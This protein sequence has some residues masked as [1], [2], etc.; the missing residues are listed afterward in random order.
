M[1]GFE[2]LVAG[3]A[4]FFGFHVLVGIYETRTF[5]VNM[6]GINMYR[7]LHSVGAVAGLSLIVLGFMDRP[8]VPVYAVTSWGPTLTILVLPIAVIFLAG[9]KG[10]PDMLRVT[11]H[12]MLWG[13]VIWGFAHLAANGDKASVMLFGSF[14][15]YGFVAMFLGDRKQRLSDAEAWQN[16]AAKTSVFPFIAII[17]KRAIEPQGGIRKPIIIGLVFYVI[18][19]LTHQ[20]FTGIPILPI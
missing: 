10:F 6:L 4:L 19:L 18:L 2:V 1:E 14:M 3:L 7:M 17:E 11:R 9:A 16:T 12:P 15:I 8:M 13:I 20:Y 5:M